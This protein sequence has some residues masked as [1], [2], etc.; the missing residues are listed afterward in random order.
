MS[1]GILAVMAMFLGP[2]AVALS[3]MFGDKVSDVLW[4]RGEDRVKYVKV[5]D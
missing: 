1:G 2:A 4:G 5:E 3:G